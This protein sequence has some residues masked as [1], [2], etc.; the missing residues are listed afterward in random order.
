MVSKA[1]VESR[2]E[3]LMTLKAQGY[4]YSQMVKV[5]GQSWDVSDRQVKRYLE[6]VKYRE[7]A[8]AAGSWK[9]Q[10]G[11]LFV[12]QQILYAKAVQS[13]DLNLVR[14]CVADHLK[15]IELSSKLKHEGE[16][17]NGTIS[18]GASFDQHELD[19]L[20]ALFEKD[21]NGSKPQ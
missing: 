7:K 2:I 10:L 12:K 8:L 13:G 9:E 14:M 19:T 1:V 15:A 18:S 11:S 5:G 3:Q 4:S 17:H 6:E 21:E 20:L 16:K